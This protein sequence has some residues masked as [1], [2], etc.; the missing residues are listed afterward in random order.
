M[1]N[2]L[3]LFLVL[4]LSTL[5]F[6]Q[7]NDS[8]LQINW[9]KERRVQYLE[10]AKDSTT[11]D[12]EKLNIDK[13]LIGLDMA[14][15]F[16]L[17]AFPVPKYELTGGTKDIGNGYFGKTIAIADKVIYMNAFFAGHN[18][19]NA[20]VLKDRKDEIYFHI[21]VLTNNENVDA[22][23]IATSRNYPDF[24]GQGYVK[25]ASS[26]IEYSAFITAERNYYAII[27]TKLFDLNF[28]KT[29]LVKPQSDGTLRFLQVAS[30]QLSKASVMEY[31]KQLLKT[32]ETKTFLNLKKKTE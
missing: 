21:I 9:T 20:S 25:L 29:I 14:G 8:N 5:C 24:F 28:G 12:L 13:K 10:N 4:Q 17:A 19:I 22:N 30:P 16:E 6:S 2:L 23:A 11:W 18:P 7:S 3:L 32:D 27:N 31:T 15:P 1:K 26:T